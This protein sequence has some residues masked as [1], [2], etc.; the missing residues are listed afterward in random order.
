[1]SKKQVENL[2]NEEKVYAGIAKRLIPFFIDNLTS[3]IVG[4]IIVKVSACII[5]GELL[6]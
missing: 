5:K 6:L 3:G 4:L 2:N 1:M